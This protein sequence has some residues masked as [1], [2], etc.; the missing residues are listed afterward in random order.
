MRALTLPNVTSSLVRGRPRG[1][2]SHISVRVA[3][4]VLGSAAGLVWLVSPGMTT[5]TEVPVAP[6]SDVPVA[7]AAAAGG[8]QDGT[9]TADL[10]VPLLAV[11]AAAV[12]GGYGWLR[13]TRR[14]RTRTTPGGAPVPP[15][16]PPVAE[17]DAHVRAALVEADDCVRTSGEE[18]EFAGESLGPAAE[19]FA[20][21]LR[22]ART[23]LAAAFRMRQRYDDGVPEEATAR[24]HALAGMTGR[25]QEA[26]R[27][28]DAVA[29]GFVR[30]R[31]LERD[32]GEAVKGA[33]ARFR[34]LTA[35]TAAAVAALADLARRYP[36]SATTPVTGFPEQAQDRLVFATARLNLAR[37]AADLGDLPRAAR[38]LRAAEGAVAQADVLVTAVERLGA[39]LT[40]AAGLVPAALT[41]AE[42]ELAAL[43]T[44]ADGPPGT[45][46]AAGDTGARLRQAD[47]VLA[48]VREDVTGGPYDPL[49]ALRRIVRAVAVLGAGRA[50]VL[51]AAALL[52]ARGVTLAAAAFVA[53]HRGA[54]GAEARTRL[55]EA[56][57]LLAAR[58]AEPL[59]AEALARRARELAAQD[60][61]QY[62]RPRAI[63]AGEASWAEGAVLAGILLGGEPDG[64]PPAA[65]GGP[66][67]RTRW[68]RPVRRDE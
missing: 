62:G 17:L 66:R 51:S 63:A 59:A 44:A 4:A 42:A 49:D 67:T 61:R 52:C 48:A 10:A 41:G 9:S 2:T 50:G 54:V 36:P 47:G 21:A 5:P 29:A 23:E 7:S 57:R 26:G 13:R 3:H 45:G 20:A 16:A 18:L 22:A 6:T 31:A 38:Q 35:R 1:V 11:S 37:Q 8:A 25:C 40:A 58:P 24:R 56:E 33:E 15:P 32:P 43:R 65:F 30:A 19:P 64:G 60:V 68:A 39:D 12:L 46:P 34:G 14:A 53:T 28:L 27:R 55:A